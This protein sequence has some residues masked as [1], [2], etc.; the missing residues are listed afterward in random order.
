VACGSTLGNLVRFVRGISNPF[1]FDID[2]IGQTVFF[3]RKENS[4]TEVIDGIYGYGHTFPEA[5]T[6]WDRDVAGSCSH[7]RIIQYKFGNLRYLVRS[8]S[9]GYL[10]D[11]HSQSDKSQISP[12]HGTGQ[13]T[14][15]P[16][17][18]LALPDAARLT[19]SSRKGQNAVGG[20]VELHLQGRRVSQ[21]QV[22]D[23]KTRS[24]FNA[25]QM[26][27]ILPRLWV[28]QVSKFI[29]AYHNRGTFEKI[30]V[31]DVKED[32]QAWERDNARA[33]ERVDAVVRWIIEE[34][35][36]STHMEVSWLGTGP[37]ILRE[38]LGTPRL[39]LPADLRSRWTTQIS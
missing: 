15:A 37:L 38:Q 23:L 11:E 30:D 24:I 2:S 34:S 31:E 9:D 28:S 19:I 35:R 7:Q 6:T 10:P 25:I 13:S 4:P 21:A 16:A 29:L 39:A 12:V 18:D 17:D 22:F 8:E 3:I 32:V 5:Y 20:S 26:D 14:V 1:R 36:G 27:E 33:L